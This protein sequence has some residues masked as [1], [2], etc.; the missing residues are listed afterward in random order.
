MTMNKI[1]II[2]ENVPLPKAFVKL[3]KMK[4]MSKYVETGTIRFAPACEFSGMQ[5]GRDGVADR[6]EGSL[7]YPISK[8][9]M[10]PLLSD[11]E[12][13]AVYGKPVKVADTAF[14]RVTTPAIQKIPFH[15]LYCYENPAMNAIIRL[16]NYDQLVKEFPDYDAAVIIHNP[17]EFLRRL[18]SKFEI[19]ANHVRYTNGTPSEDELHNGIHFLY[20][21]RADYKEQKEFRITLPTLRINNPE[22][23]EIGSLSDIA[24]CVPLKHLKYGK[25][26]VDNETDFQRLKEHC[27]KLGFGV[28]DGSEFSIM[29]EKPIATN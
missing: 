19:Y 24:Y 29:T 2:D 13:G 14:R 5:E 16:D 7:F 15:C 21:K 4:Y 3:G 25:I 28:C 17:S 23:Y 22:L 10:A 12:N 9:Y 20:Y 18:E 1:K 6:Y 8:L 11:C 26:I 27:E